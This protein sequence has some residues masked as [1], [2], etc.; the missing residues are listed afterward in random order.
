[1]QLLSL[2]LVWVGKLFLACG[3][4]LFG[5][6]TSLFV[7]RYF[8]SFSTCSVFPHTTLNNAAR[9][10]SVD[11]YCQSTR[12]QV[13]IKAKESRQN[14]LIPSWTLAEL[15]NLLSHQTREPQEKSDFSRAFSP[16]FA[17]S[18]Y[19]VKQ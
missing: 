17:D 5:D 16:F 4:I 18:P 11:Q 2:S 7:K 19:L 6:W 8:F 15:L 9:T 12:H 14:D 1:M 3:L 10:L 13:S